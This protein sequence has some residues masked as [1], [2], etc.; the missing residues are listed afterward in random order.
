MRP[1]D[2]GAPAEG[3]CAGIGRACSTIV[4][5]CERNGRGTG[6][7]GGDGGVVDGKFGG[8]S[9]VRPGAGRGR[10]CST[11][12]GSC[13]R[14]GSGAG[15]GDDGGGGGTPGRFGTGI[16]RVESST[17]ASRETEGV[18][19]RWGETGGAGETAERSG[20]GCGSVCSESGLALAGATG[21]GMADLG[22]AGEGGG[23]GVAEAT[24]RDGCIVP[25]IKSRIGKSSVCGNEV[26]AVGRL[27][28]TGAV[29]GGAAGAGGL[30][31]VGRGGAGGAGAAVG[32]ATAGCDS[33]FIR[34]GTGMARVCSK[35]GAA[36]AAEEANGMTEAAPSDRRGRPRCKSSK[37]FRNSRAEG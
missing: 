31:A 21:G 28:F 20:M 26:D 32:R 11:M 5:S 2:A 8:V 4:G 10:V 35:D 3:P 9:A 27:V 14:K 18:G 12:V 25:F 7:G 24:P 6:G 30:A 15:G 16:G 22:A 33:D 34:P 17:G 13:E 37:S 1:D 23:A 19:A 29:G 36:G